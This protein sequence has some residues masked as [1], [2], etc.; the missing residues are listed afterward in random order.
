MDEK[1][2]FKMDLPPMDNELYFQNFSDNPKKYISTSDSLS[3]V[4]KII[5]TKKTSG[6]V[7][8]LSVLMLLVVIGSALVGCLV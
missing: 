8:A 1:E 6:Y 4:V 5:E 7:I 3:D 2:E